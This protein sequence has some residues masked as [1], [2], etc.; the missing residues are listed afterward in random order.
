MDN[1]TNSMS[2]NLVQYLDGEL[3]GSEK[4]DLE[5]QLA[6]DKDL[7]NELENLKLAREAV[8]S[9][10]L[11]QQVS[12][13]HHQMMSELQAP[14]RKI[15]STRRIIRYSIAIA[16]SVVIVFMA[17]TI[18]NSNNLSSDKLFAENY[19]T[20]ELSRPRDGGVAETTIEKT[21]KAKD[22]YSVTLLADTSNN[23]KELFLGGMANLELK[24]PSQAIRRFEKVLFTNETAGT[25]SFKD[26]SEYY[27]ALAF[28]LDK[29]Y[30]RAEKLLQQIKDNPSH[31]YHEKITDKLIRN[32]KK[33]R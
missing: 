13:I 17:T 24:Y 9:Y 15:S 33:L 1:S 22:Y 8:H 11:K 20:Y 31:L 12:R 26:E 3:L 28:I 7:Q 29:Q 18:Y 19:H 23:V 32:V 27:M 30:D 4:D 6:A 14:V 16:A 5:K 2:E 10:G 25:N 21:Y